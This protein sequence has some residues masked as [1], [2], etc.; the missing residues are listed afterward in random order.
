MRK[1]FFSLCLFLFL[2]LEGVM[3]GEKCVGEVLRESWREGV[4]EGYV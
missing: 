2:V 1:V 4:G 3:L